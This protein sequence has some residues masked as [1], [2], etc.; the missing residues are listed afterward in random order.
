MAEIHAPKW[1]RRRIKMRALASI[2]WDCGGCSDSCSWAAEGSAPE[3]A[4]V[5]TRYGKADRRGPAKEILSKVVRCPGFRQARGNPAGGG[6]GLEA[7]KKLKDNIMR[8]AVQ[9]YYNALVLIRLYDQD[10]YGL[11][12]PEARK[13]KMAC[14]RFFASD[15]FKA[16]Y[17]YDGKALSKKLR[18]KTAAQYEAVLK[19]FIAGEPLPKKNRLPGIYRKHRR[20][21][22]KAAMEFSARAAKS[23][24]GRMAIDSKE[25]AAGSMAL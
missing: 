21:V 7:Y 11:W 18:E 3:G 6:E 25:K 8:Q 17:D 9:D 16:L 24:K 4:V 20:Q 19:A 10:E 23:A 12:K 5:I 2:C 1:K 13:T 15:Y 22:R 14:E